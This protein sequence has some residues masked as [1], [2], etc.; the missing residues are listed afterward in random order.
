MQDRESSPGGRSPHKGQTQGSSHSMV[1]SKVEQEAPHGGN[2][3]EGSH[4]EALEVEGRRRVDGTQGQSKA[5][6]IG[7]QA[8][9]VG[10]HDGHASS[11]QPSHKHPGNWG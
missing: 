9:K 5:V 4:R 6:Q 11:R 10:G 3:E 8:P 1:D 7:D 2:D